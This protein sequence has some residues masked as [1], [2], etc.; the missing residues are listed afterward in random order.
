MP[1]TKRIPREQWQEYFDRFS[2]RFLRDSSPEAVD[3]EIVSPTLGDQVL[4]QGARLAGLSYDPRDDSLEF[5]FELTVHETA[6]HRVLSPREIWVVEDDDGFVRSVEVVRP[7][8][9]RE[10]LNIQKVGL[11]RVR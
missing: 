1:V 8:G 3:I 5:H 2:I 7:D 11:R 10:V 9:A 6:D 4:A